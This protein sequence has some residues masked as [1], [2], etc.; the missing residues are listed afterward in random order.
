M[1]T[2][3]KKKVHVLDDSELLKIKE[4]YEALEKKHKKKADPVI[5]SARAAAGLKG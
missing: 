2:K 4:R 1:A 3:K 5:D